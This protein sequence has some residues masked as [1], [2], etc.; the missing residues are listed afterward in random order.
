MHR[1]TKI[2][3]TFWTSNC[4]QNHPAGQISARV[5]AGILQQTL[6]WL[7][8]RLALISDRLSGFVPEA[9]FSGLATRCTVCP[10]GVLM[11]EPS[12]R[13]CGHSMRFR[14]LRHATVRV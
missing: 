12:A 5:D 13:R 6:V 8:H 11:P 4:Y 14:Q 3:A 10:A 2:T 7:S 9:L 1:I